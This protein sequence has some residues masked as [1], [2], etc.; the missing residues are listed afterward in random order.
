MLEFDKTFCPTQRQSQSVLWYSSWLER[1]EFLIWKLLTWNF[2]IIEYFWADSHFFF[3]LLWKSSW[4]IETAWIHVDVRASINYEC[5]FDCFKSSLLI[6]FYLN[7]DYQWINADRNAN[8]G[9]IFRYY[10]WAA[11]NVCPHFSIIK[12]IKS[13]VAAF[14]FPSLWSKWGY[15][16]RTFC[17][18]QMISS[19]PNQ[20][21]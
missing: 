4:Y 7:Q 13:K 17:D 10:F 19:T 1:H 18:M 8:T 11:S 15:S 6:L 14:L 20:M 3:L 12:H 21:G 16:R 2:Y 5:C 9:V